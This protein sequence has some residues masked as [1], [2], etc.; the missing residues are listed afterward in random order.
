[1]FFEERDLK[2]NA[3]HETN[4]KH[5]VPWT[6]NQGILFAGRNLMDN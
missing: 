5:Q 2:A 3:V 1:V 4:R 6:Q